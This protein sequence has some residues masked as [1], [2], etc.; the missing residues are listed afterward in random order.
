MSPSATEA[1]VREFLLSEVFYDRDLQDL[2]PE[3]SLI[4]R[5]LLDSLSILK[6]VTFCEEHF[7]IAIPDAEVLPDHF[8]SVRS[9]G[10]LVDRVRGTG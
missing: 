5:G 4:E 10:A 7:G 9:I 8:E 6:I 3:E 1:A 2:K